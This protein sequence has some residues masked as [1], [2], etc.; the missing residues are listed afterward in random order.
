[1]NMIKLALL[2]GWWAYVTISVL[3]YKPPPDNLTEF[4]AIFLSWAA[5]VLFPLIFTQ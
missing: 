5:L 1:M 3:N 2:G 4:M